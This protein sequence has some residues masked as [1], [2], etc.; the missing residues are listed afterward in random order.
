MD[1]GGRFNDDGAT[2]DRDGV[3]DLGKKKDWGRVVHA[4]TRPAGNGDHPGRGAH[5]EAG[6]SAAT[7]GERGDGRFR[8]AGAISEGARGAGA[9]ERTESRKE[10]G[11]E[12][13]F[14]GARRATAVL[15]PKPGGR[16]GEGTKTP[17]YGTGG[18]GGKRGRAEREGQGGTGKEGAL[19]GL[20]AKRGIDRGPTRAEEGGREPGEEEGGG[21]RPA[22]EK[23]KRK[24]KR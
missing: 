18:A 9:G 4:E 10:K 12:A 16:E 21:K 22:Q 8:R 20:R 13:S 3:P 1:T 23:E 17:L 19:G 15:T 14:I 2:E 7:D 5:G 11:E 24:K 6:G